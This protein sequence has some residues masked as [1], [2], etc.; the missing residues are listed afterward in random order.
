MYSNRKMTSQTQTHDLQQLLQSSMY[1]T[2][3]E[4]NDD[5]I[6]AIDLEGMIINVNKAGKSIMRK[7]KEHPVA[8]N[9][10]IIFH[11]EETFF[12][13]M[14]L[15]DTQ[16]LKGIIK[17]ES[18]DNMIDISSIPILYDGE[19]IGRFVQAK[20][21]DDEISQKNDSKVANTYWE[22][23]IN[24]SAD[25]I[26]LFD[27]D[28]N[29]IKLNQATEDI[30]LYSREELIGSKV[31]TIPD[32]S[33][34][35]EVEFLQRKVKSGKSVVE[36][37]TVRKRK[38]GKLIDVAITYSPIYDEDGEMIG[39]ANILR[40]ITERKKSELELRESEAKY[41]LIA[42]NTADMIRV[43]T[44]DNEIIYISPSHQM[45][46]GKEVE[47]YPSGDVFANVHP[48]D[49]EE[50]STNY[51]EMLH[52]KQPINIEFRER[53][54]NGNWIP[55]EARCMPVLNKKNEITS[56]VMVVRDLTERK[57]T[58]ELLRNSD[59]LAVVGQ[60]AA[61]I[62][63]EI[64]NPLTSLKGF[65]QYFHS[66][67]DELSKN[68]Y[69]L[70]LSE[71]DR[72]NM[73]VSEFLLLAKPQVSKFKETQLDHMLT[74]VLTLIDSQALMEGIEVNVDMDEDLP[75]IFCDEN[76]LKQVLL[77]YTKNAIEACSYGG[78][79]QISL[80]KNQKHIHIIIE[81]NGCG[82]SE[83]DLDKIGTPFFTTKDNGTGL[84]L[85]IS[86]KIISNHDGTVT[87]ESE[88]D[89]GTKVTISLPYQ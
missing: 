54:S 33:Y 19:V 15:R 35:K 25:A 34:R 3:F 6:W 79:I 17:S 1:Q 86:K 40:D 47:D 48:D 73:I 67:G 49:R 42:E 59:K 82:I 31:V 52:K 71:V 16:R 10:L 64:R 30:F 89:K 68:Y 85:M 53:H 72:I 26:G 56:I 62:A 9:E 44:V 58:E 75:A 28:G 57:D 14:H 65:L 46:L 11:D 50:L 66:N 4:L 76:Q 8:L 7:M 80:R 45:I 51:N 87:F 74:H 43:I 83:D 77:N 41:R 22:S 2:L 81:D 61:S 78:K 23:F 20:A 32:E 24:H 12:N 84:G 13:G 21:V 18:K 55:L 27:L 88:I 5:A 63:H 36:Y 37:E 60:L 38:D 29:I 39:M 70:M 69:E